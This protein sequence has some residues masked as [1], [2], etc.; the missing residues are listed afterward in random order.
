MEM[1]KE[2][3]IKPTSPNFC[4]N[5]D[6]YFSKYLPYA[7]FLF[8]FKKTYIF[9]TGWVGCMCILIHVCICKCIWLHV[10]VCGYSMLENSVRGVERGEPGPS[11]SIGSVTSYRISLSFQTWTYP[12]PSFLSMDLDMTQTRRDRLALSV[13]TQNKCDQI[14][15]KGIL[16]WGSESTWISSAWLYWEE[17]SKG[18]CVCGRNS[19][20]W[21]QF[22]VKQ[23]FFIGGK[24]E[25]LK[26]VG[27][28]RVSY[29][30]D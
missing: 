14:I 20:L 2:E 23:L 22:S 21:M 7:K 6:A 29:V 25:T 27:V 5:I 8:L 16:N 12:M 15:L 28:F 18:V 1:Y 9:I 4:L 24:K 19:L 11:S 3:S 30:I 10:H 26:V 17:L 13:W